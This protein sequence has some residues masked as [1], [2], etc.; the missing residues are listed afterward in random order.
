[1]LLNDKKVFVGHHIPKRDRQSK[2]EEMKANFT[3]I[4]IKNIDESVTDDQFTEL[5]EQYGDV[6]SATITRDETGKSRG[7]GFV[8]YL[9]HEVASKA[10]DELNDK[11]FHGKNLYV[12]RA[13]KK[14]E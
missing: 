10:V 9:D 8:N 7:F 1:M 13:Q 12:G 6:V 5:F 14:H 11:D 4:Y 3:N 2:F